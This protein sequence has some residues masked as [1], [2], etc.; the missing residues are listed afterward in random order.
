MKKQLVSVI[1]PAYNSSGYVSRAVQSVIDQTMSEWELIIVD[2][3]SEDNTVDVLNEDFSQFENILV[4]KNTKNMGAAYSRNIAI[5]KAKGRFIA[6]LDSDDYWYP[7][8]LEKQISFMLSE[9][10]AFSFSAYNVIDTSGNIKREVQVPYS[11]S[12]HQLL[13]T[14]V[15]GCLTAIYDTRVLG[16]LYMPDIRKRQ[17]YA[18]WLSIL[19]NG[20]LAYGIKEPLACYC[21]REGSISHNKFKV[22]KYNWYIYRELENLSVFESFY[23]FLNYSV[24]GFFRHYFPGLSR[25]LGIMG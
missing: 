23:R 22:I 6:F 5:K 20:I 16:K 18:L 10:I 25:L 14:C 2:D 19:K 3:C 4:I 12:Y 17:D 8:K 13:N 15:I 1:M 11:V 21:E 9:K 24:R 7:A